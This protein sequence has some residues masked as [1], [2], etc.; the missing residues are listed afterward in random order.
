[1]NPRM[2]IRGYMN[3]LDFVYTWGTH[4]FICSLLRKVFKKFPEMQIFKDLC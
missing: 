1:M 3:L 4:M 2:A